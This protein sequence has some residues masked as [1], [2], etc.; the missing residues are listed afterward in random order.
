ML[1]GVLM[2]MDRSTA[3][4][5]VTGVVNITTTAPLPPT[6]A[7][8]A[9]GTDATPGDRFGVAGPLT[10]VAMLTEFR[11]EHQRDRDHNG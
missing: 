1:C 11:S 2:R 9:G 10:P 6:T 7:P 5:P 8:L 3:R 4:R